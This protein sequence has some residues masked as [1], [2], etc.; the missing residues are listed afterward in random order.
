MLDVEDE[1]ARLE[2]R[3]ADPAVLRDFLLARCLRRSLRALEPLRETAA[4]LRALRED[5]AAAR[6]FAAGDSAW[7]AEA[8]RLAAEC[9]ALEGGLAAELAGRD[10]YDPY[11][12]VLSIEGEERGRRAVAAFYLALAGRH[13]R[14]MRPLDGAAGALGRDTYAVAGGGDGD[15]GVWADLKADNGV[16]L[17]RAQGERGE[18]G[19]HGEQGAE[20]L[21]VR[22]TVLPDAGTGA[23]LPGRPEDWRIDTVCTR[24]PDQ[25]PSFFITHVPTGTSCFG[26]GA[27]QRE[28]RGNALR[29]IAARAL[30]AA[31]PEGEPAHRFL[32][33]G[34]D[35]VRIHVAE[36]RPSG[37]T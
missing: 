16:H 13:G 27:D 19:G 17:V 14:R 24:D 4:R 28:A 33:P 2:A 10:R 8:D 20:D 6:E 12:A 18:P 31:V 34:A 37:G 32:N 11:D 7:T 1:C 5:L 36:A 30:A 29:Q 9:R 21:A 3:L 35:P 25:P 26:T 22:V 23:S 15:P